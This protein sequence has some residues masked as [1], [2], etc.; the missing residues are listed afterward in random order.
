MISGR[1]GI[2]SLIAT[3]RGRLGNGGMGALVATWNI[4]NTSA[5][6]TSQM[7]ASA[8]SRGIM[9]LGLHRGASSCRAPSDGIGH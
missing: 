1:P 6:S 5:M 9:P 4:V 3:R 7:T 2:S 8:T